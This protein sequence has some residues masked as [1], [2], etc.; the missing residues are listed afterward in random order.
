VKKYTIH[1][2]HYKAD[3]W[4]VPTSEFV[5]DECFVLVR[6]YALD[7]IGG[8]TVVSNHAYGLWSHSDM[9]ISDAQTI[10]EIICSVDDFNRH[11]LPV[12]CTVKAMANQKS[13]FVVETPAEIV[14]V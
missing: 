3:E 13:L 8:I 10:V 12:L 6:D 7:F 1:L 11:M 4:G 5:G 9:I 14:N 2:P